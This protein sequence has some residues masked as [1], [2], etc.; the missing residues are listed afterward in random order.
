MFGS[1]WCIFLLPFFSISANQIHLQIIT[2]F[3][4]ILFSFCILIRESRALSYRP[5]PSRRTLSNLVKIY[6]VFCLPNIIS[7]HCWFLAFDSLLRDYLDFYLYIICNTSPDIFHSY[8]IDKVL[9]SRL[10]SISKIICSI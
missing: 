2:K 5:G 3:S 10:A 6:K 8:T 4:Q 7:Q 1:L 9:S